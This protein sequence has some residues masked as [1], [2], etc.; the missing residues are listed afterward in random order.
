MP[1]RRRWNTAIYVRFGLKGPIR[2]SWFVTTVRKPLIYICMIGR[3]ELPAP[4]AGKAAGQRERV[5]AAPARGANSWPA[6]W[7]PITRSQQISPNITTIW[8]VR[9]KIARLYCAGTHPGGPPM[10][11]RERRQAARA[12]NASRNPAG[13]RRIRPNSVKFD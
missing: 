3:M 13:H 8:H 6:S 7:L 1:R 12:P 11:V 5:C 4:V 2:F 10:E 9:E